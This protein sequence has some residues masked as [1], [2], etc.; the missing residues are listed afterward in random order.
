MKVHF[1]HLA[2]A[3]YFLFII[4]PRTLNLPYV[5]PTEDHPH[6]DGALPIGWNGIYHSCTMHS[7]IV[8]DHSNLFPRLKNGVR[9]HPTSD[10]SAVFVGLPHRGLLVSGAEHIPVIR[11]FDGRT[12]LAQ[13]AQLAAHLGPASQE[14]HNLVNHLISEN[15]IDLHEEPISDLG[16]GVAL[17]F[18]SEQL[19][20]ELVLASWR[21][22]VTDSGRAELT[23]RAACAILILGS[24]RLA[25]TL[26]SLLL[27]IGFTQTKLVAGDRNF[28]P[29]G[30]S[31]ARERITA[32]DICGLT[33]RLSDIGMNKRDFLSKTGAL[34]HSDR[35]RPSDNP[36]D[37][38]SFPSS[39][40]LIITTE[41]AQPDYVQRWMSESTPYLQVSPMIESWIEVGP[42]VLP[43]KSPCL[44]C[45]RL[46]RTRQCEWEPSLNLPQFTEPANELPAAAVAL[47]AGV[48][49]M[50][51]SEFSAYDS[52][53]LI[54]CTIRYNLH[55]AC[56]PEHIYWQPHSLCG[57]ME[58][59]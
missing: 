33:V 35:T 36:D 30:Y 6:S 11:R 40:D 55:D 18:A 42:L 34:H 10:G 3:A 47:L 21:H 57:C 58:V 17:T 31:V 13:L 23:N 5:T 49:A 38:V 2:P 54:G 43:G 26:H 44:R 56:K 46:H 53:P 12:D 19:E 9:I 15:L 8:S 20:P 39:P 29:G 16:Q 14:L 45:V 51:V 27:A 50:Q 24:N 48:L 7:L 22:G 25:L 28:L 1:F 59:I 52:S 37:E 41:I 4:F 32:R